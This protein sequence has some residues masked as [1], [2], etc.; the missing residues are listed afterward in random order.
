MGALA[1]GRAAKEALGFWRAVRACRAAEAAGDAG[2]AQEAF[3]DI[4]LIRDQTEDAAIRKVARSAACSLGAR[5]QK[6]Q[7]KT[8]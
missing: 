1:A 7:P 4:L 5:L 2:A 6:M 3:S 8:A